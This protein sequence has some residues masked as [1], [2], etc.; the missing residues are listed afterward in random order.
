[1]RKHTLPS[2]N[3]NGKLPVRLLYTTPE[4]QSAKAPK[5][6][7]L[8][9]VL[10]QL[11]LINV[12]TTLCGKYAGNWASAMLGGGT[13]M[14]RGDSQIVVDNA[15]LGQLLLILCCG[16][17]MWPLAIAR[18]GLR[19][20]SISFLHKLGCPLRNPLHTAF[21]NVEIFG[22]HNNWCANFTPFARVRTECV[23]DARVNRT[24]QLRKLGKL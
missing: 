8:A 22:L 21:N 14:R 4:C 1:M 11:S 16:C 10:L 18:L 15:C 23:K 6:N 19:Y 2:N 20:L 17:F 12:G 9:I 24:E 7:T 3:M 13:L 5:Q